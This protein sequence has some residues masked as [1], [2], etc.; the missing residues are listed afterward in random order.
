MFLETAMPLSPDLPA[1]SHPIA[2]LDAMVRKSP[3]LARQGL[4][5]MIGDF[6]EATSDLSRDEIAAL[7]TEFR[8][9]GLPTLSN[10]RAP[11]MKQIKSIAKRGLIRSEQEYYLVRSAVEGT[12]EDKEQLR[13]WE[14]LAAFEQKLAN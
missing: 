4:E 6:L 11:F 12:T 3:A 13:L 2:V 14:L 1:E 7:D 5:M 10:I 9:A 8:Q